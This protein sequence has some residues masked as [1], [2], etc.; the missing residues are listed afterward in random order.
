MDGVTSSIST[1]TCILITYFLCVD[2]NKT[3]RTASKIKA[4][5]R[6]V[7]VVNFFNNLFTHESKN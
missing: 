3:E 4:D 1:L 7:K 5:L 2:L 6:I